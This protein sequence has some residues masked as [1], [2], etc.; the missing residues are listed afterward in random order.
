MNIDEIYQA[1]SKN[2]NKDKIMFEQKCKQ[3]LDASEKE[4]SMNQVPSND[5]VKTRQQRFDMLKQRL[6]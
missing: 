4:A 6:L 5:Q 1:M 3:V 2:W